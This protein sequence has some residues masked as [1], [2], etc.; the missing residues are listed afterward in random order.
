[1]AQVSAVQVYSTEQLLQAM[2]LL[3]NWQAKCVRTAFYLVAVIFITALVGTT[4][5]DPP[6]AIHLL[7]FSHLMDQSE[8][9]KSLKAPL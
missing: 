5:R 1:M 4:G 6:M 8:Q 7:L 3:Y 2:W 9:S